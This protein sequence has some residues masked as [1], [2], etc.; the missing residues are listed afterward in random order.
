MRARPSRSGRADDRVAWPAYAALAWIVVF[1]AFHVYWYAGGTFGRGGVLP[2]LLPH[3]VIGWIFEV[4]VVA[5]FPIGASACLAIARGWPRGRLRRLAA[6]LVWFGCALL[7]LRGASGL[8][9]DLT[10][11]IGVLPNGITGLSIEDATG[12]A[13][14]SASVLWS[15]RATDAYFFAGGLLFGRLAWRYRSRPAAAPTPAG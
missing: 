2:G 3:S 11:A 1:F 12:M 10:R 9:D 8:V 5:A 4:A 15:G 14:P 6:F 13:H 7:T